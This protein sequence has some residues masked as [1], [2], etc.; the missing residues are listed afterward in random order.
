AYHYV[1]A[2]M[3]Q[4]IP[5]KFVV[6]G[7][8]AVI[9]FGLLLRRRWAI[10]AAIAAILALALNS[11][12]KLDLNHL[13]FW[14]PVRIIAMCVSGWWLWKHPEE[15]WL[16]G[17][18]TPPPGSEEDDA[19]KPMISLVLLRSRPRYLEAN[20]LATLLSDVWDIKLSSDKD[21]PD[22]DGFV[23]GEHPPFHVFITK[24]VF[25]MFVL[26]NV[27]QPYFDDPE[28]AARQVGNLRVVEVISTHQS[29][30]SLDFIR[31]SNDQLPEQ[32]AYQL[33]GKAIAAL[34]DDETLALMA[35]GYRYFNFWSSNLEEQLTGP[36][37]LSVF[38][39]EVKAPVIGV[40]DGDSIEQAI[41]EARRR[42]PEFVSAFQGRQPDDKRFIV[43]APFTSEDGDTEHMWLEVFGLEPE[44]VH[45]HLINEPFHNK[46]LKK[47]SQ[48]EVPVSEISD[49][50]CPDDQGN[51][52]GNFTANIVSKAATPQ[53]AE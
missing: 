52:K 19:E 12:L 45:G 11:V 53:N 27:D 16:G 34:A 7:I 26:H 18:D 1:N 51:A 22:A 50:L 32:A 17:S 30:L 46:K 47:G 31:S 33:I 40:P 44:Y 42:W 13:S 15:R 23:A 10:Y 8:L 9:A 5:A 41:A 49:W 43:K 28:E 35:P 4:A 36:D 21:A 6:A 38:R 29:W 48:V 39:E 25:G 14:D 2:G 24:P 20:W 37:P 3:R